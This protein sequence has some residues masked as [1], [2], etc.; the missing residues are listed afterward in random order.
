MKSLFDLAELEGVE[1]CPF[2]DFTKNFTSA[3]YE[4]MDWQFAMTHGQGIAYTI[5][6]NKIIKY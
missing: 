2:N 4:Y 3:I 5:Y 1:I 6:K